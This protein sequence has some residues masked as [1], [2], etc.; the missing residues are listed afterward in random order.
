M[1]VRKRLDEGAGAHSRRMKLA[2]M[3]LIALLILGVRLYYNSGPLFGNLQDE[4]IYLNIISQSV[5]FHSQQ[6]FTQF[7]GLNFS[8]YLQPVFNPAN[9]FKFYVG[10][11]YPQELLGYA[12]G[13][14]T[15]IAV[16]Y[17]IFTSLVEGIAIMLIAD[18]LA[19]LRAAAVSG[20]IF[21]FF[22]L[23][24]LFSSRVMPLVPTVAL[25]ALAVLVFVRMDSAGSQRKRMLYALLT[26]ALTGFAY[27]THPE[28]VILLFFLFLY[29]LVLLI[30]GFSLKST[31]RTLLDLALI[32]AGF[33]LAYSTV[34]FYYLGSAGNFL[35]YPVADRDVFLYQAATQPLS[36]ITVMNG[37]TLTYTTGSPSAYINLLF[38][39]P[40]IATSLYLIYGMFYF[41]ILGYL[42]VV[43]SV[44]LIVLRA[45]KR[46]WFFIS[47]LVFYL[48]A[49]SLMP[50]EIR[51]VNGGVN[52]LIVNSADMYGEVLVLPTVIIVAMGLDRLLSS[53]K[54]ALWAV[55]I[56][57]LVAL[58]AVS[59]LEMNGDAAFNRSSMSTVYS[60]IG[61]LQQH[62]NVTFYGQPQFI[63]DVNMLTGF[64][65]DSTVKPLFSCSNDSIGALNGTY[66]AV[67]G[68]VSMELS[69]GVMQDF[70]SC[71]MANM[72]DATLAFNAPNP[73]S[74]SLP[75][76]V[77]YKR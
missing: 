76:E 50:T 21:A 43:F 62:P 42:A 38:R 72:T 68:T 20:V 65:Y 3:A 4:G 41:S 67:G 31:K 26:G 2:V 5:V 17:V 61:F 32:A 16:Y 49:L 70:D 63:G 51:S 60:F 39:T 18:Y 44:L 77:F 8:D 53:K 57:L 75:L 13:F 15:G 45:G 74:P 48:L 1:L 58:I 71:V 22:P 19:G 24:A 66:I 55:V 27:L 46:R 64:K 30:A 37:V 35:L 23:D 36:N 11:L 52:L 33:L 7:R 47:M 40:G 25:L 34:G 73:F 54:K 12:F 59:I 10:F 14:S 6:S 29:C 69:P 28:G 9:V 56:A